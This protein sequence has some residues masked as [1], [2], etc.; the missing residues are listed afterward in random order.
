MVISDCTDATVSNNTK[1]IETSVSSTDTG[2]INGN[3]AGA[4]AATADTQS[5]DNNK[6]E[7]AARTTECSAIIQLLSGGEHDNDGK[8]KTVLDQLDAAMDESYNQAK[9]QQEEQNNKDKD[10]RQQITNEWYESLSVQQKTIVDEGVEAILH[11]GLM[12]AAKRSFGTI[13]VQ[14]SVNKTAA[15][16]ASPS[17]SAVQ[18]SSKEQQQQGGDDA[19]HTNATAV[20]GD[21]NDDKNGS[22]VNVNVNVNGEKQQQQQQTKPKNEKRSRKRRRDRDRKRRR[23][24]EQ[25]RMR[26]HANDNM[27]RYAPP[28]G[29]G[30]GHHPH[31]NMPPQPHHRNNANAPHQMTPPHAHHHHHHQN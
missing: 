8:I 17:S 4:T 25:R 31:N 20:V 12:K 7:D 26:E 22:N 6:H 14:K 9:A 23:E 5:S 21:K 18:K 15:A 2:V 19:N 13:L 11:C 30:H 29:H 27:D 24:R 1:N 3:L 16:D 10:D 28:L